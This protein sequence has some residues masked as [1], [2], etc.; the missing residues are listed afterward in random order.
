M[1]SFANYVSHY[2]STIIPISDR[3]T[4]T[5]RYRSF[6][7]R[8]VGKGTEKKKERTTD[9]VSRCHP[10]HIPVKLPEEGRPVDFLRLTT[11]LVNGQSHESRPYFKVA[12]SRTLFAASIN[13]NQSVET[14]TWKH[15]K[16]RRTWKKGDSVLFIPREDQQAG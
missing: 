12:S 4:F 14:K 3:K 5:L 2:N 9:L 15:E 1:I 13:F 8:G 7:N 11:P 10:H 16:K 6:L